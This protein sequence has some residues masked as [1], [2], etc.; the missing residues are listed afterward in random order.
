MQASLEN[1]DSIYDPETNKAV[2]LNS[3]IGTQIIKNYLE[4]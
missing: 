3:A 2:P 4:C 1:F